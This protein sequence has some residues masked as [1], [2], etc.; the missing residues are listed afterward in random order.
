MWPLGGKGRQLIGKVR[1]WYVKSRHLQCYSPRLCRL[2][3]ELNGYLCII[4]FMIMLYY[5]YLF[6]TLA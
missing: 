5:N 2:R 3:T 4:R 6:V 1:E